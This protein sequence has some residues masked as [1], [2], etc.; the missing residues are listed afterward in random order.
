MR[1]RL[2]L[3][4][5]ATVVVAAVSVPSAGALTFTD[6][7]C[8]VRTG[9]VIKVCPSGETG[10]AYSYQIRGRDGTGCVPYVTFKADGLP[11][12]LSIGSSSGVVSG[13]P[14]QAGT[15]L[16]WV[17]MQDIPASQGGVSWCAD[18]AATER[19]FEI[20]I[21]LG[22]QILQRQS[23]LALGQLNTPY[24]L[25]FGVSGGSS[26][27]WS[28][29]GGTL[30]AGL[31]LNP[32]SGLL[33]GTPTAT[34]DYSF[35]LTATD[36]GRSDTQSY[37]LSVVEPLKVTAGSTVGEV[38]VAFQLTPQAAGGKNRYTW[39]LRGTLPAGLTFDSTTGAISGNPTT[40]GPSNATLVLSDASGLTQ[41]VTL[42][43]SV[44]NRLEIMRASLRAATV[45]KR[46]AV[47]LHSTGG[48][49]PR[50]WRILGGR[51][52]V[53]P[54]GMVLNKRTGQMSGTPR[55]AGVYRLRVQV[56]DALGAH[57]AAGVVLRV[58]G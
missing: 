26:T 7:S 8:V 40:A 56:S 4:A 58:A 45:G 12:G 25:Q 24:N 39:S 1:L 52:G 3:V 57:S 16:F 31:T 15:Y 20:S 27:T 11:P 51:S 19:Q 38:G 42:N 54:A 34:G 5:A 18:N 48:V 33:S 13:V 35:K 2:L 36:A 14:K 47:V 30:P 29:T 50:T 37:S 28:V 55:Q 9:T 41:T 10:K 46:Y 17:T 23:T 53:L 43:F 22:L 21:A 6:D 32:S 49:R 44:V